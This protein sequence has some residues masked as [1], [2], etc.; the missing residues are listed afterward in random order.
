MF[1]GNC[2]RRVR[3]HAPLF[4]FSDFARR[5]SQWKSFDFSV[6]RAEGLARAARLRGGAVQRGGSGES[7]KKIGKS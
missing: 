7:W 3:G 2:R 1:M 6:F 4:L 5:F